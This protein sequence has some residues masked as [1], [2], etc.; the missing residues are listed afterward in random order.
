MAIS[1]K[2]HQKIHFLLEIAYSNWAVALLWCID[3]LDC[4]ILGIAMLALLAEEGEKTHTYM[5]MYV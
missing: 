2:I 3:Q 1:H 5:I 4:S